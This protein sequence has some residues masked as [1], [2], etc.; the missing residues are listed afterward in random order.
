MRRI[1]GWYWNC[2]QE[3]YEWNELKWRCQQA[4]MSADNGLTKATPGCFCSEEFVGFVKNLW[5]VL[6]L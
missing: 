4:Q 2:N 3:F 1:C 6:E 5:V